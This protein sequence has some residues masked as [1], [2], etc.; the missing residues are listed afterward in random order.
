MYE[1]K[2]ICEHR[3][4]WFIFIYLF[5]YFEL[6]TIFVFLAAF[7]AISSAA[8]IP[9]VRDFLGNYYDP[10]SN[11]LS[12]STT[13]KVYNILPYAAS[14]PAY[15]PPVAP[16]VAPVAAPY[17]AYSYG[18]YPYAAAYVAPVLK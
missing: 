18:A 6:Q 2:I 5:I 17:Y 13:G 11:Q 16:V 10:Y 7:V 4:T 9:G 14:V 12:S 3:F 1:I 15:V 8:S